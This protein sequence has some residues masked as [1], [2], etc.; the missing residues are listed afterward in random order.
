VRRC[1]GMTAI[2]RRAHQTGDRAVI[3]TEDF[4]NSA[5]CAVNQLVQ[6]DYGF[7]LHVQLPSVV[8][9]DEADGWAMTSLSVLVQVKGGTYTEPGVRLRSDRWEQLLGS[10]TPVYVAAVPTSGE[11]WIA[12]VEE[13]LPFGIDGLRTKSHLAVPE[14]KRWEA[15]SFVPEAQAAALLAREPTFAKVVAP[16]AAGFDLS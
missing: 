11:P 12:L 9:A 6:N 5:G 10:M 2:R 8:P 13:L 15:A 1:R 7:D 3:A 16:A 14:R 4:L